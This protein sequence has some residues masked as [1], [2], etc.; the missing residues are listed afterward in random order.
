MKQYENFRTEEFQSKLREAIKKKELGNHERSY[1]H[2]VASK[3][4]DER[5]SALSLDF[6]KEKRVL[7]RKAFK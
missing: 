1:H 6:F 4:H 2:K 7:D 5:V 3:Y